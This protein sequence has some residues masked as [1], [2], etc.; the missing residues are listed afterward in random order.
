[1]VGETLANEPAAEPG[2][3]VYLAGGIALRGIDGL[4]LSERALAGRQGRRIFVRLVA[5]GEAIPQDVLADDLWGTDWPPAWQVALRAL[6][7]KL[8]ATLARVG[9][10]DAISSAGGTYAISLPTGSWLDLD[11]AA[12][13]VH[14]AELAQH[15]S[16]AASAAGWALAA[17]AIASR[18]VLP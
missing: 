12:D 6:V 2:L 1:V 14:R 9:A 13:A 3:R 5:S 17:R 11:T 10:P 18:P 16:Q 7:S 4:T 8:R 15:N